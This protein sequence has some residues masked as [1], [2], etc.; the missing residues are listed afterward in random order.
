MTAI[1]PIF[2]RPIEATERLPD[3]SGLQAWPGGLSAGLV[4]HT[5]TFRI[6]AMGAVDEA[7][8]DGAD[9]GWVA[10][11]LT[12]TGHRKRAGN[13]RRTTTIAVLEDFLRMDA[14]MQMRDRLSQTLV[15]RPLMPALIR[16]I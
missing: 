6:D 5:V 2:P 9:S 12:P 8:Q 10:D 14:V 3:R 13:E 1:S 4:L 16:W 15:I 7:I 11:P